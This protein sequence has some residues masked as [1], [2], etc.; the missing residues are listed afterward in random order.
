MIYCMPQERGILK[1]AKLEKKIT[2]PLK[3]INAKDGNAIKK[4]KNVS[5]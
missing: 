1:E 2:S 4:H 3:E 5:D